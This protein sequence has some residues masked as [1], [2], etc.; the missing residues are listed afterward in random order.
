GSLIVGN[1]TLPISFTER[2]LTRRASDV[3]QFA[4]LRVTFTQPPPAT[5]LFTKQKRLKL[6]THCRSNADFQ[7]YILL[8]Y[9]AYRMFNRLTPASFR[10]RLAMID[11]VSDSGKPITSRYGFFIEDTDDL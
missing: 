1:E 2:G 5:S 8:E 4:P 6:V 3:C 10:A 11:Y 7:Q 9:A